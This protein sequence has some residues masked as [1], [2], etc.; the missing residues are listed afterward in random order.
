MLWVQSF[1]RLFLTRNR[2]IISR[3]PSARTPELKE[4]WQTPEI[5]FTA[6]MQPY[7]SPLS[8]FGGNV[9]LNGETLQ[10]R[11][12]YREWA[13]REPKTKAALLTKCLAVCALD[14]QVVPEN[15][16]DKRD[17]EVARWV[18]YALTRIDGGYMELFKNLLLPG[19]I[20]G[21][22]LNEPVW[23]E[24][25]RPGHEYHK[26]WRP[27]R[28]AM[29]DTEYVKFKIDP[30]RQIVGVRPMTGLA[31]YQEIPIETF[32]FFSHLKMFENPFGISDLRAVVRDVRC[33]DSVIQLRQMY[34]NNNAGPFVKATSRSP[35]VR[36]ELMAILQD[37]RANGFIV[38]PE[39]TEVEVIDIAS[40]GRDI[41]ERAIQNYTES[42]VQGIQGS[43]L[44]L[45]EGGATD[46]RGNT[47]VHRSIAELFQWW[48][49]GCV[50]EV[51]NKQLIPALVYPNYGYSVGL[52]RLQLGGI[53]ENTI[54]QMLE[55]F[56]A[57]QEIGVPISKEQVQ[58]QCNFEVP[59]DPDD[60]LQ[61]PQ[62]QGGRL[63]DPF[64]GD[65]DSYGFPNNP[66]PD[67]G[68]AK[69]IGLPA[70]SQEGGQTAQAGTFRGHASD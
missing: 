6:T 23:D 9:I 42:I 51:I 28:I 53:D 12:Q 26:F 62:T 2:T 58:T 16:K 45:L 11:Q 69:R 70:M 5:R 59:L 50:C 17:K 29:I 66:K 64:A 4:A 25:D 37:A 46:A 32:L 14:P 68:D 52:P 8:M 7:V 31:G 22:S 44:Q 47:Q 63:P 21:F 18:D 38:V 56:R 54:K 34:L 20:D 35:A 67:T 61:P 41:F 1:K 60:I 43:Y 24:Y 30:Y 15:S 40:S 39:G 36:E 48:L 57:G 65:V 55:R 3:Y 10:M 27:S 19:L 49:A 13:F 33:L